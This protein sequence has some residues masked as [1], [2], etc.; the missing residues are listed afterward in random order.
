MLSVLYLLISHAFVKMAK[1]AKLKVAKMANLYF[2][3]IAIIH[4][5]LYLLKGKRKPFFLCAYAYL[6][7]I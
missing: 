2:E 1:N 3:K 4:K 5:K 6:F 7:K